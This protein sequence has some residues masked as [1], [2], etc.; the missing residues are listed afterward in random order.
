MIE[1]TAVPVCIALCVGCAWVD[2]TENR[3]PNAFTFPAIAAGFVF[4]AVDSGLTGIGYALAGLLIGGGLLLIPFLQGGLG[5][6]DVKLMAAVGSL[7]GPVPVLRALLFGFLLGGLAAVIVLA[8]HGKLL[9]TLRKIVL[10]LTQIFLF[11]KTALSVMEQDSEKMAIPLGVA[12]AAGTLLAIADDL[13]E[14]GIL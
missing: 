13:L 3:I 12:L 2:F 5:A 11:R 6:G 4:W 8:R 7:L 10:I 9:Y 1:S 14:A